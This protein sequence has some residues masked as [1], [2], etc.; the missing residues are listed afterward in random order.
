M[1]L[2]IRMYVMTRLHAGNADFGKLFHK[3][4]IAGLAEAKRKNESPNPLVI[5]IRK[6]RLAHS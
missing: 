6:R 2:C 3:V 4:S 5:H 1:D